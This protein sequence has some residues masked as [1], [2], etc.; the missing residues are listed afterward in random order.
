MYS[1][2]SCLR[3]NYTVMM[4]QHAV[5]IYMSEIV[6]LHFLLSGWWICETHHQA[7]KVTA[8]QRDSYVANLQSFT[9]FF[10]VARKCHRKFNTKA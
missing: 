10:Q 3:D 6:P 5:F 1:L 2:V 9:Y 8:N 7:C 4:I